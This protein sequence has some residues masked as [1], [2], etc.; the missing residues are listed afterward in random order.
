[1]K[2]MILVGLLFWVTIA[3]FGLDWSKFDSELAHLKT[4]IQKVE[5]Y[6]NQLDAGQE[7]M[8]DTITHFTGLMDEI[9]ADVNSVDQTQQLITI[10]RVSIENMH[11]LLH[12]IFGAVL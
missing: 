5:R 4:D 2:K 6:R 8:L 1:M 3:V 10:Q 12:Q 7:M 9:R 11:K